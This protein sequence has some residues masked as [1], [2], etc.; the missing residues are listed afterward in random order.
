MKKIILML[1]IAVSSFAAFAGEENVNTKVL[2]AF[3]REFAG[4]KNVKWTENKTFYK[5]SF[6]FNGQY[7]YAFYQ[8]DGELMAITRNISSLDLPVKLQT[9]LK[10]GYDGYWISELFEVSNTGGT[11]YY[12]TVEKADSKIVLKSSGDGTWNVFKKSTKL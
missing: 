2:N 1:A 3:S 9:N 4:A 7:V 5:A 12:I 8:V 10:N 6:V 11:K